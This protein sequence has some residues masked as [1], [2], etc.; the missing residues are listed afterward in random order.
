LSDRDDLPLL[1]VVVPSFNQG[2][3]LRE[4]LDSIFEQEYPRLEVAVMD[5]GSTDGS[6]QIIESYAPR[7]KH[8]QTGPDEGQ[9]AAINEGVRHC[10]G[11]LV[12][13]LNSDDVHWGNALW[14]VGRAYAA[15]PGAGLYIGN[16]LR[17]DQQAG[18]YVPFC[19]R[20]VAL[21]R[22]ALV[23]GLD[24]VLQPSTFV[25]RRAWEDCGGLRTGLRYC[26]DWDLFIRVAARYPAVTIN[27]FLSASREHDATKTRRGGLAR[28]D[29]IVEMLRAHSGEALTPG[30]LFY[31]IEAVLGAIGDEPAWRAVWQHLHHAIQEI[32]AVFRAEHGNG[33]GFPERGDPQDKVYLPLAAGAP[34]G[35]APPRAAD[36]PSISIVT[37]SYGHARFLGQTLDS[38]LDQGYPRLETLVFDGGS[39]DG[40][41]ALLQAYGDRLSYWVSEPDRGPAHAINKGLSRAG[42]DIVSWLNSDDMLARDALW[43]IGRAFADDPDLDMVVGNALYVDEET[44]L[45]LAD[46]GSYRTALYYGEVQPYERIPAYWEYVHSVP[47]PT[48]FF[49][50]RLLERFGLLDESYHFI[51]DFELFWRFARDV[52]IRKIERTLA[53][54][55]IHGGGK[56]SDWNRFLVELYHFSRPLWPPLGS[57]AFT[58]TLRSFL[59]GYMG[60]RFPEWQHD[61]RFWTI[62]A[63]VGACAVTRIGNPEALSFRGLR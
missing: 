29:E 36:L 14:H 61:W 3:Y 4:A 2:T 25:S 21:D 41:V 34:S 44:R 19:K 5:G 7:L 11:H 47:Q 55:R 22:R 38:I 32:R 62:G 40:S 63:L 15:H 45:H 28:V 57:P 30:G 37:P 26:M 20:H 39:R 1:S 53:F 13:W 33:D 54:Y 27:E 49:R 16:G 10:T 56:T 46:H 52:K 58:Q 35:P 42:G 43:E 59:K 23:R 18:R 51:F 6:V 12:A 24:Y 50:R 31:L 8:W 9:A 60:R 17:H 48:V